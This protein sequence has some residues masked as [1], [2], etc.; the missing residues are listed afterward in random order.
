MTTKRVPINLRPGSEKLA[1]TWVAGAHGSVPETASV[2][3][4]TPAHEPQSPIPIKR[5]TI[6]IP[7]DLH[8][9]FKVKAASE[10]VKMADLV[11]SWIE[12]GC[13]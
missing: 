13:A 2:P 9:R 1:D 11:R 12:A 8:R 7:E 6:D 4:V 10:G 3:A 5:L